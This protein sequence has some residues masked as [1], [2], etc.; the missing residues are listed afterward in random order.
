MT[1]PFFAKLKDAVARN[2]S[3]ICVGLDPDLSLMP[4]RNVA[5]F[6][7]KIIEATSDL[8]C[9]Y[10][11]NLAFFEA[12]GEE[13]W[14]ALRRTLEAIPEDIPVIAD[15]KRG[16]IG[17]TAAA[18]A[19]AIFDVLG[20]D[21]ATVNAYGG[22]DAVEPFL[23]YAEK[24]VLVWCRSSNPSAGEFQDLLVDYEGE[25]RPLWQVVALKSMKWSKHDNAGIVVGAT[26]PEQLAEARALAPTATILVPGVGAQDG[27]LR[28]SVLAGVTTAG[29]GIIVSASRSVIYA[30]REGD[31]PM[32][33]RAAARLLQEQ[34]NLYRRER[35]F[36]FEQQAQRSEQ[37]TQRFSED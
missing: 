19:H 21:A 11:P 29:E 23:D 18:Y 25:R 4:V 31:Y 6:N 7:I 3:L 17:N 35:S 1:Q 27:S 14:D 32:A 34:V 30:S 10:K 5:E 8:V 24:G 36:R 9:C 33:A 16:D 12:L 2:N 20:C 37:Q 15:A 28:D 26:Y 22:E 13:G